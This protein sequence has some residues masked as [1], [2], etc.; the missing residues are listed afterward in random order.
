MG[1]LHRL[2]YLIAVL[3][4]VHYW[5]QVKLPTSAIRLYAVLLAILFGARVEHWRTFSVSGRAQ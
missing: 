2:V 4:V 5:W 1:E 3:G